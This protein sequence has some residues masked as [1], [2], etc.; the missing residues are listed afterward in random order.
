MWYKDQK[1]K[2]FALNLQLQAIQILLILCL[3]Y[4]ITTV[5]NYQIGF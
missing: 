1:I 5:Q 2:K 4:F 3:S